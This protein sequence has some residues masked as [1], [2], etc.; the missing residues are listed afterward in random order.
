MNSP[1]EA[2]KLHLA[3][4]RMVDLPAIVARHHQKAS[5][6][7][8]VPRFTLDRLL[9]THVEV[10]RRNPEL[11][12]V[13]AIEDLRREHVRG[14]V[15]VNRAHHKEVSRYGHLDSGA[16]RDAPRPV[17]LLLEIGETVLF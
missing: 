10:A 2:Y 15:N 8:A 12:G 4:R 3:R 7:V 9:M 13:C 16:F 11:K 6:Q 1:E 14:L 17:S 5:H